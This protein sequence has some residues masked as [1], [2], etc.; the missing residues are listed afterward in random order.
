MRADPAKDSG[1]SSPFGDEGIRP[2]GPGA[3]QGFLREAPRGLVSQLVE[4]PLCK[5]EASGS[6]PDESTP[7]QDGELDLE[8]VRANSNNLQPICTDGLRERLGARQTT[9][10]RRPVQLDRAAADEAVSQM[11]DVHTQPGLSRK[12]KSNLQRVRLQ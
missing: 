9:P 5:R 12:P 6:N 1:P 2:F 11:T 10:G 3:H 7:S 8:E 4:S